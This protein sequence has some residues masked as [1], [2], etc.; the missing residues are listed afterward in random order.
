MKKEIWI[1]VKGFEEFAKVS[2]YGN[3]VRYGRWVKNGKNQ[4]YIKERILTVH[5]STDSYEYRHVNIHSNGKS[6]TL[7][8]ARTVYETFNDIFLN[9]KF[10]IV[11]VDGN[12]GNCNLDNLKVISRRDRQNSSPN[13][14]GF[15]GVNMIGDNEYTA[16]IV[17]EGRRVTVHSSDSKEDCMKV[18]ELAKTLINSYEKEKLNILQNSK[19]HNKII[20]KQNRLK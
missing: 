4:R 7:N 13:A 2:N 5:K 15:T 17:F 10:C 16:T 18:Y 9:N 19:L 6:V 3:I 8:V 11:H 1:P 20:Q 14:T 12:K